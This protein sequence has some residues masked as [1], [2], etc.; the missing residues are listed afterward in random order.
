MNSRQRRKLE[1]IEHQKQRELRNKLHQLKLEC[2][3]KHGRMLHIYGLSAEQAIAKYEAVL[4]GAELM[5]KRD[6]RASI[7][8]ASWSRLRSRN[9][10]GKG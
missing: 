8:L 10:D 6:M 2:L 7:G 9:D 5:P 1:A 3:S 4:S